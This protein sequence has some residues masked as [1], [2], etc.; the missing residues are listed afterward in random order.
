MDNRE[1]IRAVFV[2]ML[3]A[4]VVLGLRLGWE[5]L[6]LQFCLPELTQDGKALELREGGQMKA[7]V[8]E[9]VVQDHASLLTA[10]GEVMHVGIRH[11][12]E[13]R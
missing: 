3:E 7:V 9:E 6:P 4:S 5:V 11:P 10:V 12:Q 2:Y 13:L 8:V 1:W